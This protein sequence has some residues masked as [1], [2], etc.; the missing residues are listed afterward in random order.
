MCSKYPE[1]KIIPC[2][3]RLD[4]FSTLFHEFEK[5]MNSPIVLAT[6][7]YYC[8]TGILSHNYLFLS[9]LG[10]TIKQKFDSSRIIL[11][12][13]ECHLE[14][15]LSVKLLQA[16]VQTLMPTYFKIHVLPV[17]TGIN[18]VCD[19]ILTWVPTYVGLGPLPNN[20]LWKSFLEK[21]N[22]PFG[23]Y[24]KYPNLAV[25]FNDCGGYVNQVVNLFKTIVNYKSHVN[26]TD[27]TNEEAQDIYSQT[28]DTFKC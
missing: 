2:Y 18:G 24:N 11:H 13:D 23:E 25:A 28:R 17:L 16:C 15:K 7:L 3:I 10:E 1:K 22:L 9:E 21:L 4:E 20:K 27:L 26:G 19:P 14:P 5:E 8:F 6:V 12:I